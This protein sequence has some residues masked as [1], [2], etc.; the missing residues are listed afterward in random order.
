M[1]DND[2]SPSG[3]DSA[4]KYALGVVLASAA[5]ATLL[6][7]VRVICEGLIYYD[8]SNFEW[9][10]YSLGYGPSEWILESYI[11]MAGSWGIWKFSGKSSLYYSLTISATIGFGIWVASSANI[12]TWYGM[13]PHQNLIIYPILLISPFIVHIM[14]IEPREKHASK[15]FRERVF[16]REAEHYILAYILC[17]FFISHLL[18]FK[19]PT[20]VLWIILLILFLLGGSLTFFRW[21]KATYKL[22]SKKEYKVDPDYLTL[23]QA[24]WLLAIEL[25][26]CILPFVGAVWHLISFLGLI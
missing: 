3:P 19:T 26:L 9:W 17:L 7:V 6:F 24:R 10:E 15:P 23:R 12:P 5:V 16:K 1:A 14:I 13:I 8:E 11:V 21:A 20:N 18:V 4:G 25:F 22:I 2:K